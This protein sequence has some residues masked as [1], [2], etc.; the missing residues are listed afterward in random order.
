MSTTID[1]VAKA[2]DQS[3]K[4]II[5][6]SSLF[7]WSQCLEFLRENKFSK[8]KESFINKG[9]ID[10]SHSIH[11]V[12]IKIIEGLL[13]QL[14]NNIDSAAQSFQ[15]AADLAKKGDYG[16][17]EG[18]SKFL[19]GMLLAQINEVDK[20]T[21][22]LEE[23]SAKFIISD[24]QYFIDKVDQ[25]RASLKTTQNQSHDESG[26]SDQSNSQLLHDFL[27]LAVS[28]LDLDHVLNI[29]IEYIMN[30]TKA[31]RSFLI[32]L[33]ESGHLYSQVHRS[34]DNKQKKENGLF[35]DFSRSITEKVLETQQSIFLDN[36]QVDPRFT[37]AE[38]IASLDIRS[39]ICVPL[40]RDKDIIG[41]IYIDR[42]TILNAFTSSDLKLVESLA[43]YA[44]IS[45]INARLHY[46]VQK[47]LESSIKDITERK[48]T[49][50]KLRD[51]KVELE[52]SNKELEQF[53]MVVSHDLQQPLRKIGEFAQLLDTKYKNNLDPQADEFIIQIVDAVDR[54]SGL[55]KDILDFSLVGRKEI[56]R[57]TIDITEVIKFLL[58]DLDTLIKESGAS[59]TYENLPTI[60]AN[61]HQMR[62]LFQNLI[63]NAIKF[64]R[65]DPPL[66]HIS[67]ELKNNE[68]WLFSIKDNG[69]GVDP[70]H[71]N[72]IFQ[73][74]QRL[75]LKNHFPGSGVGLAVCKKIVDAYNGRIWVESQ[76][77]QGAIFF[78]TIPVVDKKRINCRET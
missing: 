60:Q 49:E 67:A 47:K 44:T 53:A 16:I 28:N 40:K 19:S 64:R 43:E 45:L 20:A 21:I 62:Q 7:D 13:F 51:V 68:Y 30:I 57:E 33:D 77:N 14:E 48:K 71:A 39:V 25:A 12:E 50:K 10:F 74:F 15:N 27:K 61:S 52:R 69:I 22:A 29:V 32:L 4:T 46:D 42:Q 2:V 78:F 73:I 8:A 1:Y 70:K 58:F 66:I 26:V 24:N 54:L 34:K 3:R 6:S 36:A 18:L 11:S 37:S 17:L 9:N 59:I 31:D 72:K 55:T 63:N 5:D 23:A 65:E 41:L 35:K 75:H 76:L 56:I 38:S